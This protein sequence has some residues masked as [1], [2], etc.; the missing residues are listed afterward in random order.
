[1]QSI[2]ELFTRWN[3]EHFQG[4]LDNI[5]LHFYSR[6]SRNTGFYKVKKR[7]GI[8][9]KT[10]ALNT[11]HRQEKEIQHTL[12][13]E[14]VHAYLHACGTSWGHTPYFKRLLKDL[15]EKCFGFRPT[16]NVRFVCNVPN[17]AMTTQI[18]PFITIPNSLVTAVNNMFPTPDATRFRILSTGKIGTLLKWTNVY[19]KK[20][21]V[22]TNVEGCIFP[23]TTDADNVVPC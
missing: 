21:I 10:I 9:T 20:H 5:N 15:T 11:L 23:F 17:A 13:H 16:S 6:T 14:M 7:M 8:I 22:L 12:L 1:M 3:N 4:K 2:K 19:G 18:K